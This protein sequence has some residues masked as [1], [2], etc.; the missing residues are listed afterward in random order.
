MANGNRRFQ[1]LD[2]RRERL[3][4]EAADAIHLF[5]DLAVLLHQPRIERV[6]LVVALE[7]L[8]RQADVEVVGA[9]GQEVLARRRRL[10][11][12]GRIDVRIEKRRLQPRQQLIERLAVSQRKGRAGALGGVRRGGKRLGRAPQDELAGGEVVE[13]PAVDPEQLGVAMD[14]LERLRI[15]A[16]RVR[17]DRFEHVAHLEAVLVALV[18]V[19]VAPGDRRLVEMPDQRLF[20]ERQ[21]GESVGIQLHDRRFVDLFEQ[22]LPIGGRRRAPA[23]RRGRW[24]TAVRFRTQRFRRQSS[25]A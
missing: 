6:L 9:R 11:G 8:H 23:T 3:A 14:L 21:R 12:D 7:V 4:V 24:R 1:V 18:V 10:R 2:D 20:L 13:R 25:Q 19:D 5:D 15:D 17:E 22:V 16:R